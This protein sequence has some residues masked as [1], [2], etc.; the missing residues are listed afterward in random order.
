MRPAGLRPCPLVRVTSRAHG[1]D[2][3]MPPG[4][5]TPIAVSMM[6]RTNP[7]SPG[8]ADPPWRRLFAVFVGLHG[9]AHLAGAGDLLNRARDD[10]AAHL[11]ADTLTVSDPAT[12]S[13]LGVVVAL[14]A[15]GYLGTAVAIWQLHPGWP[16]LLRT[17][18]LASLVVV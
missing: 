4:A 5:R 6:P 18:T 8:Y 13:A 15:F 11:L 1:G 16:V 2:P 14:V 9:L 10:R 7:P 12:V 3:W 17:V